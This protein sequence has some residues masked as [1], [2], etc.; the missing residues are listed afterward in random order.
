MDEKKKTLEW[1]GGAH[2]AYLM[3]KELVSRITN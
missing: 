2:V 3:A 1:L